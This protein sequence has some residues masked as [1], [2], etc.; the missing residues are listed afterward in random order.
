[1]SVPERPTTP[2]VRAS[3]AKL[4]LQG[5]RQG[6]HSVRTG[7]PAELRHTAGGG[8]TLGVDGSR[9]GAGG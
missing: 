5:A 2:Q 8:A 1:P 6:P 4:P 7:P 9:V 3:Y